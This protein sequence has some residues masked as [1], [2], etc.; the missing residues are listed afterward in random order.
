MEEQKTALTHQEALEL[1]TYL[2]ASTQVCITR[3]PPDYVVLRLATA[4]DRIAR[5]WAPRAG[6][7]LAVYLEDLGRRMPSEVART[8]VDLEGF[9]QYL[10]EQISRLADIVKRA[11][12]NG[13]ESLQ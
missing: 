7:E 4:A 11:G 5:H 6:G 3:D 8:D 10:G 9:S 12:A 1:I 13:E 2:L